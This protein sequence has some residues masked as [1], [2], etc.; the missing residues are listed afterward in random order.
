LKK[1]SEFQEPQKNSQNLAKIDYMLHCAK[2]LDF[3]FHCF[4]EKLKYYLSL[5]NGVE[6]PVAIGT[7]R[8]VLIDDLY[9][10]VEEFRMMYEKTKNDQKASVEVLG[11]IRNAI[12]A[13]WNDFGHSLLMSYENAHQPVAQGAHLHHGTYWQSDATPARTAHC[14]IET[15]KIRQLLCQY[16]TLLDEQ[17][18][19][20]YI[21]SD[22]S[23]ERLSG[24]RS[25]S[26]AGSS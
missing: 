20:L 18:K 6:H 8:E 9:K 26:M 16:K 3:L 22:T 15:L 4:H 12:R 14:S 13:L 21:C 11:F 23:A 2:N 24:A 1:I 5:F 25:V 10:M 19:F 17:Q 7:A